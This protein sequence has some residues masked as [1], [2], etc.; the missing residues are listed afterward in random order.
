MGYL[1]T[2][3]SIHHPVE[4]SKLLE[5]ILAS[6]LNCFLEL[7]VVYLLTKKIDSGFLFGRTLP[8]WWG[9]GSQEHMIRN[10]LVTLGVLASETAVA[11]V[12]QQKSS[13]S[14]A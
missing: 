12:A 6:S 11:I 4:T 14:L 9:V 10:L 2:P 5:P 8:S 13:N 3:L 1:V 7:N